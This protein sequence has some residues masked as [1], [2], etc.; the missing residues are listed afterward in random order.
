VP[1]LHL[2]GVLDRVLVA[3]AVV[4]AGGGLLRAAAAPAP[5]ARAA[6]PRLARLEW[7]LPLGALV[8]LFAAFVAL[9]LTTLFGGHE[10]VLRTT[11]LTY[12]EYARAGFAQLIAVAALT[13][14]VIAGALHWARREGP[15]DE[16]LLRGLLGALC[17]LTLV[18]LASALERLG[19]YEEAYGF[20]RLRLLAHAQIL[21][22]GGLFAL[23]L[24]AGAFRR[25]PWLPR[26]AVGLSAAAAVV[27]ALADPDRRIAE[28]NVDRYERTGKLDR[29]Y[30]AALSAD[31]VPALAGLPVRVRACA[32]PDVADGDGV[33]GLNRARARAR[34]ALARSAAGPCE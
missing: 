33:A 25:A 21:W 8:A 16:G 31:A 24:A 3:L 23:L 6:S 29:R 9:Q 1:E 15:V 28:R 13:L 5:A 7:T 34:A 26:A 11:G 27:F 4:L 30:L 14:A 22:L 2:D 12:A 32:L 17:A 18:V 10:H 19:L 20:T